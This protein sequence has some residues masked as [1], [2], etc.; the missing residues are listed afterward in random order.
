[1]IALIAIY[2]DS[3]VCRSLVDMIDPKSDENG[4]LEEAKISVDEASMFVGQFT[5]YSSALSTLSS[6]SSPQEVQYFNVQLRNIFYSCLDDLLSLLAKVQ[7]YT[8]MGAYIV[9][10]CRINNYEAFESEFLTHIRARCGKTTY[11]RY[12][13]ISEWV[14]NTLPESVQFYRSF[15]LH[16]VLN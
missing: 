1:M 11:Y 8:F 9:K 16:F 6:P 10:W 14:L 12:A 5:K 3:N 2:N 4:S 13:K 7:F 15:S